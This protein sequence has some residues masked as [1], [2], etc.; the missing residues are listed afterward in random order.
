MT[1]PARTLIAIF[2][3]AIGCSPSAARA[4]QGIEGVTAV[5]GKVSTDYI[6]SK[7]PDGASAPE[8]Y[9]FGKGGEWAGQI[10]DPTLDR[11]NFEKVARVLAVALA[12]KNYLPAGDP[13]K[14]K[15]LIMVYW[16]MT[17]VSP[18]FGSSTADSTF[19]GLQ[20][21][22]S[23]EMSAANAA[24]ISSGTNMGFGLRGMGLGTGSTSAMRD[25]Q[26]NDDSNALHVLSMVNHNRDITDFR[27]AMMLGYDSAGL[28]ATE[29]GRY[30]RGTAFDVDRKDIEQEIEENRYFV[31]LMA[32]DFQLMWKEKK[33]KL[34]WETRFSINE[35]HNEF[36][37][38]LPVMARF[39]AEYFGEAS[40]GLR[41]SRVLGGRVDI[42]D[43]RSLGVVA[44][45]RD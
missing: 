6:R 31:V 5:S 41:R 40:N 36:A 25:D 10:S 14:T 13:R 11:E 23:S 43:V 34:L 28:I 18:S 21:A 22:M 15:L 4:D 37:T 2:A 17:Y 29:H 30:V 20:S 26:L 8:Y 24:A 19:S 16:G 44:D 45:P 12:G 33:H 7:L 27:N 32:Y 1:N 42:G 3:V 9:A 39:A 38:A 35:Q